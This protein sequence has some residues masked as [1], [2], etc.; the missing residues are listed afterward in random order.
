ME[1]PLISREVTK[2]YTGK[3]QG[4]EYFCT[5]RMEV[6][7]DITYGIFFISYDLFYILLGSKII[8]I[9]IVRKIESPNSTEIVETKEKAT[10]KRE[11]DNICVNLRYNAC[12][13]DFKE[14]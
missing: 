1:Y 10:N 8:M 12:V 3:N 7:E 6:Y 9:Y 4:S 13:W 11:R 14:K 5:Y 2:N